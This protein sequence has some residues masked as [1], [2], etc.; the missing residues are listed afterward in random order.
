M[1]KI[2]N[3]MKTRS[4]YS[5]YFDLIQQTFFQFQPQ[6]LSCCI[7]NKEINI[8][9]AQCW[10]NQT[11]VCATTSSLKK[12]YF[13]FEA[14]IRQVFIIFCSFWEF[15][16]NMDTLVSYH[17]GLWGHLPV[18]CHSDPKQMQM[19][20]LIFFCPDETRLGS[21]SSLSLNVQG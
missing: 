2:W 11:S 10:V 14:R 16:P 3:N 13:I 7:E 15:T 17:H 12:F 19:H 8:N 18:F 5:L 9:T 1:N 6:A 20:G 4:F 21:F